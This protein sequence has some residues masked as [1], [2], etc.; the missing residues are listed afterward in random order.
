MKY[1]TSFFSSEEKKRYTLREGEKNIRTTY[2]RDRVSY[3]WDTLTADELRF[4]ME[5]AY[6]VNYAWSLEGRSCVISRR[7]GD[8]YKSNTSLIEHTKLIGLD[9]GC[10]II[11][12]DAQYRG[13]KRILS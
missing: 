2:F 1:V 3:Y 13:L 11:L 9:D 8:Y 7:F 10:G 4:L 5:D 6:R 12:S